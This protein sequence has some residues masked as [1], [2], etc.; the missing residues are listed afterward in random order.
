MHAHQVPVPLYIAA[1]FSHLLKIQQNKGTF[2]ASIVYGVRTYV[3][4]RAKTVAESACNVVKRIESYGTHTADSWMGLKAVSPT[5]L[6]A[7]RQMLPYYY[8]C[9]AMLPGLH[10]HAWIIPIF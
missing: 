8:R 5:D 9:S 7:R 10:M 3:R 4:T 2:C 1:N 6:C